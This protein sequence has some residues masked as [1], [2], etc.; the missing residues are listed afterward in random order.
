M[1]QPV[2]GVLLAPGIDRRATDDLGPESMS[3]QA[4]EQGTAGDG[5]SVG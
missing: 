2:G 1:D 5:R 3:V 4:T